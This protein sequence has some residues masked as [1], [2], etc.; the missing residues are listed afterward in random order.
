MPGRPASEAARDRRCTAE[1]GPPSGVTASVRTAKTAVEKASRTGTTRSAV[2][3]SFAD[4]AL[5]QRR[6]DR[7]AA[8]RALLGEA[9]RHGGDAAKQVKTTR[10]SR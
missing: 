8:M 2:L 9:A 3:R 1:I 7:A 5:R 6:A 10:P 4:A